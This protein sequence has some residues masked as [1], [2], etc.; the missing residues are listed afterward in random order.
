MSRKAR[1]EGAIAEIES[2]L[3]KLV[4]RFKAEFAEEWESLR[5]CPLQHGLEAMIE[6]LR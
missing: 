6:R 1:I 2:D 5:L 3:E 4:A